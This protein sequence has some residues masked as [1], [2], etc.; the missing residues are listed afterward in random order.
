MLLY[1]EAEALSQGISLERFDLALEAARGKK[2][3]IKL[4]Y[5]LHVQVHGCG[6]QALLQSIQLGTS[7]RSDLK[8]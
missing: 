5:L 7:S 8:P 6:E 2:D 3:K 4:A 1:D